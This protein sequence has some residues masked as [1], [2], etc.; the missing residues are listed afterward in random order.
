LNVGVMTSPTEQRTYKNSGLCLIL[1]TAALCVLCSTA[2]AAQRVSPF[3]DL[4]SRL[5]VLEQGGNST[6]EQ[7]INLIIRLQAISPD[8]C[9]NQNLFHAGKASLTCY[10]RFGQKSDL[11][12]AVKHLNSYADLTKKGPLRLQSLA[13]I[14]E[15]DLLRRNLDKPDKTPQV[16]TVSPEKRSAP[17]KNFAAPAQSGSVPTDACQTTGNP[18]W[19]SV[20]QEHP[21]LARPVQ[22]ALPRTPSR[23]VEVEAQPRQ[24]GVEIK[25]I[26]PTKTPEPVQKTEPESY[27]TKTP[28]P[29]PETT[30]TP[31]APKNDLNAAE[32]AV[33][34]PAKPTNPAL[35][36]HSPAP[37]LNAPVEAKPAKVPAPSTTSP[38]VEVPRAVPKKAEKPAEISETKKPKPLTRDYLVIVDPGHGGKDPGAVSPDKSVTEKEITLEIAKRFKKGLTDKEPRISVKLTRDE[39]VH[40]PLTERTEI[41]NELKADLFISIHCNS[42]T[43]TSS[44]GIETYYLDKATSPKALKTAAKENG[45][46]QE[47]M[48][49]VEATLLDLIV[50]SNKTESIRLANTVQNAIHEATR[51]VRNRGVRQAPFY[52]LL[53]AKMPSILVEC[54]FLSNE[55]ERQNLENPEHLDKIAEGLANGALVYLQELGERN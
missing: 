24:G 13:M 22:P 1:V 25:E 44:R 11:D 15:V 45:I 38:P 23:P 7:W 28:A 39:D 10:K 17:E 37:A 35:A 49:D 50:T 14:R 18:F 16:R 5:K 12:N 2:L 40:I 20:V 41:A 51:T 6:R 55:R 33:E 21:E 42:A 36:S 48:S 4:A 53:G 8:S 32:P 30:K 34:S 19:N 43:D 52:V 54:A 47:K 27:E 3:N 31:A 9:K 26:K 46:P 29:A